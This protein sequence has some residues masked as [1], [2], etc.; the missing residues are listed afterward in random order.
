MT[1]WLGAPE[2]FRPSIMR[3]MGVDHGERRTGL[4]LSDPDGK[5]A[6]PLAVLEHDSSAQQLEMLLE[7][8]DK[9]GAQAIVLG[10]PLTLEGLPGPME[11]KVRR[12]AG[13]LTSR[14]IRVLLFDER[15]STRQAAAALA[16]AGLS[17]REGRKLVDQVAAT[18]VLQS[19]LESR[20]ECD[21]CL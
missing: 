3:Y 18:L 15:Y 12:L 5:V 17:V 4:A 7:A 10:R 1:S 20:S 6:Y 16:Q 2:G 19:F 13:R 8:Y 11:R 14:S 21:E 9:S